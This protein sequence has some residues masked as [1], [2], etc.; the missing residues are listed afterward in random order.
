M[1]VHGQR[2]THRRGIFTMA[3]SIR[4]TLPNC[5]CEC[6]APGK[7]QL[8][9]CEQCRHGWVAHAMDKLSS[10]HAFPSLLVEVVHS[11]IAFDIASL[12][13][14]GTQ[15]APIRLRILLDRLFSVLKSEEVDRILQGLGWAQEDYAR[16]YILQDQDGKVLQHWSVATREEELVILNQFL[17][18][19]ETKS[20]AEVML[21]ELQTGDSQSVQKK[22]ES[23]I[24]AFIE[25]IGG[26]RNANNTFDIPDVEILPSTPSSSRTLAKPRQDNEGLKPG[27]TQQSVTQRETSQS[28]TIPAHNI[29]LANLEQTVLKAGVVQPTSRSRTRTASLNSNLQTVKRSPTTQLNSTQAERSTSGSSAP[30]F[31]SSHV[32][33]FPATTKR[34]S[35]FSFKG[36]RKM[37]LSKRRNWTPFSSLA[38]SKQVKCN[39]C[40]KWF[41]DKGTWKIHFGAVHLKV[42]YR[43]KVEGC[44][45]AFSSL[46]SRNRH[47]SNP[48]P[49]IHRFVHNS[50][51][52]NKR[53]GGLQREDLQLQ[54]RGQDE[55]GNGIG[56]EDVTMVT[57]DVTI[58]SEEANKTAT[59]DDGDN[60]LVGEEG[61]AN[62][63]GEGEGNCATD[64]AFLSPNNSA[65]Q[66]TSPDETTKHQNSS[67]DNLVMDLVKE[68]VE[69]STVKSNL[70]ETQ[71]VPEPSQPSRGSPSFTVHHFKKRKSNAPRKVTIL[72]QEE[73]EDCQVEGVIFKTEDTEAQNEDMQDAEEEETG[74]DLEE[75][76]EYQTTSPQED[77]DPPSNEYHYVPTGA[78]SQKGQTSSGGVSIIRSQNIEN[79]HLEQDSI[80]NQ[81]AE[82]LGIG[83]DTCYFIN[84]EGLPSCYLCSKTFQSKQTVK[85]HYQNVH[86][87][88]MHACTIEGCNAMFPSRRSRD[89][90]STNFNLHR[91]LFE[92][93]VP[94]KDSYDQTQPLNQTY[95]PPMGNAPDLAQSSNHSLSDSNSTN[96]SEGVRNRHKQLRLDTSLNVENID[97][98]ILEP[99]PNEIDLQLT[100]QE[101]PS[102]TKHRYTMQDSNPTSSSFSASTPQQRYIMQVDQN[103]LSPLAYNHTYNSPSAAPATSPKDLYPVKFVGNLICNIC[104]KAYST[105]DTL[106]THYKNIHLR[107]MHKC[108]VQG[109]NLMFSSVRSRN[110]HSQNPNLHRHCV[111][112]DDNPGETDHVDL[113]NN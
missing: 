80:R 77:R 76:A 39:T 52:G 19:G 57:D 47:S 13:L 36:H 98:S 82:Q 44:N 55:Q 102:S 34:F 3:T 111:G 69:D 89:R 37:A 33:M 51:R 88:L 1:L 35:S 110:R 79:M 97:N 22:N 106:R 9:T 32:S 8:R 90:H 62:G 42:K 107:E 99:S 25:R 56:E 31:L 61:E 53:R 41:Y 100:R 85:V 73:D 91:K 101:L 112:S 108:T 83:I 15:A 65:S 103:G 6:F 27:K 64:V 105:K 63:E 4:C 104:K 23:D 38:N 59:V 58:L 70:M 7:T 29:H 93:G 109:C 18:F 10:G 94:L 43:C 60:I 12:M 45:M 75:I 48:N 24:R 49:R 40:N 95:C 71:P 68:E 78:F 92:K 16:G 54:D 50:R 67:D 87:K 72:K 74:I 96:S 46:R 113:G 17:R 20:I 81:V 5:S 66:A 2:E 11:D 21:Q 30:T 14:Y 86:L 26:R 84:D 28:S